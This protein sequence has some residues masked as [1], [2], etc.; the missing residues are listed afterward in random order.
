MSRW[1]ALTVLLSCVGCSAS[2]PSISADVAKG[3]TSGTPLADIEGK[4]GTP[5]PPTSKQAK[6]MSDMVAQMPEPMRQNAGKDKVLAW[7]D[8]Q[9]YFVATVNNQGIAWA[10]VWKSGQ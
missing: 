3:I 1:L 8:D 4:L 6:S 5:H 9:S 7:G 10:V 2:Y